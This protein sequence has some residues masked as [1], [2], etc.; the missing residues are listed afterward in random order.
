MGVK[1]A[2]LNAAN[3][4]RFG[5]GTKD[6]K[7][8]WNRA[9]EYYLDA[10][11]MGD[12]KAKLELGKL[13]ATG[14]TDGEV[15]VV[16]R[17]LGKSLEYWYQAS[18]SGQKE[19]EAINIKN[20][21]RKVDQFDG[22]PSDPE[23]ASTALLFLGNLNF[24]GMASQTAK[25]TKYGVPNYKMAL[26]F[27]NLAIQLNPSN[28][29][30]WLNLGNLYFDGIGGPKNGVEKNIERAT[31]YYERLLDEAK[32]LGLVVPEKDEKSPDIVMIAAA[33]VDA[34]HQ[35]EDL[36]VESDQKTTNRP[37]KNLNDL[38]SSV[39]GGKSKKSKKSWLGFL[40]GSNDNED[41]E[42]RRIDKIRSVNVKQEAHM[43]AMM[44]RWKF[45]ETFS[46]TFAKNNI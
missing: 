1:Q 21:D 3:L 40:T 9:L 36:T 4:Y 41:F 14:I 29:E 20:S 10:D 25:D 33:L 24:L 12:P 32:K 5:L 7:P 15:V 27:W 11:K 37:Q 31:W 39:S 26:E 13:F 22:A 19:I 34:C 38:W 44:N 42:W 18:V 46:N 23:T 43:N 45:V 8:D 28:L 30:A 35:K 2:Y 16:P 6:F 17:D